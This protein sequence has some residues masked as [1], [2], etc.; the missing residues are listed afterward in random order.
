MK[1]KSYYS[2]R[3]WAP[4]IKHAAKFASVLA[5]LVWW[6]GAS[7][8]F[9]ASDAP[10]WMHALVNAP[11]PPH[12][13][14]TDAVLLYAEEILNVQSSG[15]I[16]TIER[17]AY[18]ILRPG[19][20][21]RGTI[22]ASFDAETRI[23]AIHGWCIPAQGKDYEVK[24]KD[25][26][27]TA[28]YGVED[29]ELASDLRTKVLKIPAPDPGNIVG[30]EIEHEDRPYILQ[31]EWGFQ[32]GDP[33]RESRYTL[34]LPPGWEYKAT[35][36]NYSP[37]KESPIGNNQWQWVA[38]NVE[39][40]REERLMPAWPSIAGLMVVS[41]FPPG[42]GQTKGFENW[43]D[44]GL[45][46]AGLVRGRRDSSSEIKQKVAA[47]TANETNI[48]R[49]MAVLA[50]FVQDDIRYV[51]IEL[52]IGGWQPHA[53]TDT[54]AH[55]FGDCKDKA[56]LLSTMLKEVGV[57]SYYIVI[58]TRRGAVNSNTPAVN[59]FNH[60]ILAIKLPSETT[61]PEIRAVLQHKSLGRLLIFDPTDDMT[62]FGS[63]RGALQANF[64]LLVTDSGG[65]LI[66]LPKLA[67]AMNGTRRTAKLSLAPNGTLSGDVNEI[68]IG[69]HAAYERYTLRSAA[70]D[71][72]KVK[73]IESVLAESL[74]NYRL[75]HATVSN[76]QHTDQPFLYDY[77]LVVDNYAK[78]AGNLLL[79]RPRVLGSRSSALLETKE[80]RKYPVEFQGPALDSDFFEITLPPG[81]EVSD[82]PP[83][84]DVDYDFASYHS[85]SEVAGNTLKY[86]R[87]LEV[88]ELTVPVAQL[89]NLKKFYRIIASDERNTAVLQPKAN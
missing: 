79:V 89:D 41:F 33:V 4:A 71:K 80:P 56:T 59:W 9:A 49:K 45:W 28:L 52:G 19:G 37:I 43:N 86:T 66:E 70:T 85:K 63:L 20:R 64:G 42:G 58:N 68:R 22:Y 60:V 48:T 12:D 72:D 55:H 34:Q 61:E 78:T 14:K 36:V 40:I 26:L 27:E 81:Y 5:A 73:P 83:A 17:R 7:P 62:P 47:L 13:E 38:T 39:A 88:K 69:D 29:G 11:L 82:L 2:P 74:S 10:Q 77:S 50:K 54:F 6:F 76:L 21:E 84:V 57:D 25:V 3:R 15:K 8:A 87:K 24:D 46:E 67:P 16:K 75:T 18:K 35:F 44:M 1:S 51:A 53:A 31:D 32:E 65:E 23:T 30:Y